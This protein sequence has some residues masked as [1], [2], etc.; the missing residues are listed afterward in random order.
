MKRCAIA[1]LVL[2]ASACRSQI[3][4]GLDERDANEAVSAL[5]SRGFDARKVPEKGKKP[6]WA[7]ELDDEHATDALRVLTELKLPRPA[8]TTTREVTSQS[9]LIETPGAER[10]RQLEALEGDIEQMIEGMDGVASAGIEL[11]VPAPGR[12]GQAP[13]P[14]KASA[15]IRAHPAALERLQ[16]QQAAIRALIAGSVDG[17]KADEVVVLIDPVTSQVT[18]PIVLVTTSDRLRVV[19]VVMGLSLSALAAALVALGLKLRR[20]PS[21]STAPTEPA[22]PLAPAPPAVSRRAATPVQQRPVVNPSVQRK[23]A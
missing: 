4:H 16:Q 14:S 17:L 1:F 13:L 2:F 8:R 10:L 3:Q 23:V 6:T 7:I 19:V 20:K 18:P 11:V 5:V 22:A 15:L 9:A 12:P 21:A